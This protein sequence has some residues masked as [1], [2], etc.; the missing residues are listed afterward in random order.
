MLVFNG[1]HG[2]TVRWATCTGTEPAWLPIRGIL[3]VQLTMDLRS[4]TRCCMD[5]KR[6][7]LKTSGNLNFVSKLL[8]ILK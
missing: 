6:D 3:S 1:Q 7:N 2:G 4:N 8:A 5:R